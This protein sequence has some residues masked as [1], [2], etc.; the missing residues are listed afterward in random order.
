MEKIEIKKPL[1]DKNSSTNVPGPSKPIKPGTKFSNLTVLRLAGKT[2]GGHYRYECLCNCGGIC[3]PR[4]VQLTNGRS[5]SCGRCSTNKSSI[6]KIEMPNTNSSNAVWLDN[7]RLYIMSDALIIK[8][9]LD[10]HS[11]PLI[12]VNQIEE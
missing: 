10:S 12:L 6:Q 5:K 9:K 8:A 2:D 3:T 1:T 4:G 11:E 7:D